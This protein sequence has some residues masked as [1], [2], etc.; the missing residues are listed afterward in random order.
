M[1]D[2]DICLGLAA[3]ERDPRNVTVYECMSDRPVTCKPMD[4]IPTAIEMMTRYR[5]R[6]LPVVDARAS[7]RAWCH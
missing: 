6:R 1:T 3:R 5:V 4:D 7:C 2:R